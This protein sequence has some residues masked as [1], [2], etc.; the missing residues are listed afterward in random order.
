MRVGDG[1]CPNSFR[2]T[3]DNSTAYAGSLGDYNTAQPGFWLLVPGFPR[4]DRRHPA[5][6]SRQKRRGDGHADLDDFDR[7]PHTGRTVDL[8]CGPP[9]PPRHPKGRRPSGSQRRRGYVVTLSRADNHGGLPTRR[10][11]FE[12]LSISFRMMHRTPAAVGLGQ[13]VGDDVEGLRCRQHRCARTPH[14][15]CNASYMPDTRS[16]LPLGR[17]DHPDSN[18]GSPSERNSS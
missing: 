18:R 6:R 4:P 3:G 8:A 5:H 16:G 14:P 1:R 9:A 13:P 10:R 7:T 2:A 11:V 17:S 15:R 12:V